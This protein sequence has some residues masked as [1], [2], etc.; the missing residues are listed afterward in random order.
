VAG[1]AIFLLAMAAIIVRQRRLHEA[2]A[3]GL[4]RLPGVVADLASPATL[5]LIRCGGSVPRSHSSIRDTSCSAAAGDGTHVGDN[6]E[7]GQDDGQ[8]PRPIRP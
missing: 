4:G 6:A 3:A 7:S 5:A 1:G 2:V 8:H